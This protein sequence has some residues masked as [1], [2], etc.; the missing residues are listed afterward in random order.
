[1]MPR[2]DAGYLQMDEFPDTDLEDFDAVLTQYPIP[3]L[4]ADLWSRAL[5]AATN[6]DPDALDSTPTDFGGADPY[7]PSLDADAAGA[8]LDP[9]DVPEANEDPDTSW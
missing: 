4:S 6:V 7:P 5:D 8:P 2:D 9:M 3:P 1:M